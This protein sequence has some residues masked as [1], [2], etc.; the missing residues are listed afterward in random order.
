MNFAMN[1]SV[2]PNDDAS[3][4]AVGHGRAAGPKTG[5]VGTQD[6]ARL[7]SATTLQQARELAKHYPFEFGTLSFERLIDRASP[8]FFQACC[9]STKFN[10]AVLVKRIS[11]GGIANQSWRTLAYLRLE[12]TDVLIT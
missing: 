2:T 9:S 8:V 4:K 12:F 1:V 10:K 11:Q 6:F 7:R 3:A 5:S